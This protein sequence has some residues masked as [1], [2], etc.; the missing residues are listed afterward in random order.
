MASAAAMKFYTSELMP[1][2]HAF[3]AQ[4]LPTLSLRDPATWP[5]LRYA[6]SE[7]GGY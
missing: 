1:E 2:M 5:R 3:P 4:S 6:A 7:E